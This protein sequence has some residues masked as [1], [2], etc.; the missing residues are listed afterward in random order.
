MMLP[1]KIGV[2]GRIGSG[3]QWMSWIHLDDLV[4]MIGFA[5][6][7]REVSGAMNGSA[8][9]PVTNAEFTRELATRAAPAGDVSGAGDCAQDAVRRDVA[10]VDW[11]A[12]G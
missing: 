1:F 2:G 8:P 4:S 9:G 3:E 6:E 12:S 7:H 10:D 11:A 5:L